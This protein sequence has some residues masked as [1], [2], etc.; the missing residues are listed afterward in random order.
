[1]KMTEIPTEY[2][3]LVFSGISLIGTYFGYRYSRKTFILT[4]LSDRAKVVKEI[5]DKTPK[6]KSLLKVEDENWIFW[7]SVISEIVSSIIILNKLKPPATLPV[8]C[9]KKDY[10]IIFWEQIPTD[11][12]IYIDKYSI[13]LHNNTG[14]HIITFRSQMKTILKSYKL[15]GGKKPNNK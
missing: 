15:A 1:M 12:R 10:H 8:I 11:L 13:G 14:Q 6:N 2:I 3:A 4:V 7:S 5:W 9:S